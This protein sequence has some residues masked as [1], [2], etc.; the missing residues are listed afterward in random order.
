MQDLCDF[1]GAGGGLSDLQ[2]PRDVEQT[3][4]MY[5]PRAEIRRFQAALNR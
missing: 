2:S 3:T 5:S 1:F 4:Q